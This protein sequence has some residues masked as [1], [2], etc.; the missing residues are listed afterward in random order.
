MLRCSFAIKVETLHI[1]ARS[2]DTLFDSFCM[3]IRIHSLK[4]VWIIS[5][6]FD[7]HSSCLDMTSGPGRELQARPRRGTESCQF[8]NR[9]QSLYSGRVFFENFISKADTKTVILSFQ[10]VS[11]MKEILFKPIHRRRLWFRCCGLSWT[12]NRPHMEIVEKMVFFDV[13]NCHNS[14]FWPSFLAQDVLRQEEQ[15]AT[16]RRELFRS[17]ADSKSS[18]RIIWIRKIRIPYVFSS[19]FSFSSVLYENLIHFDIH[20]LILFD[21]DADTPFWRWGGRETK[22]VG[23]DAGVGSRE[24]EAL[25]HWQ[26]TDVRCR[27]GPGGSPSKTAAESP[28]LSPLF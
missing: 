8:V 21:F 11:Q 18:C 6:F 25:A 1:F 13:T 17:Q 16:R 23:E 10:S 9:I 14:A 7:Y 2:F 4:F 3:F 26:T 12:A 24:A 22:R 27:A 5:I 28:S 20:G 15:A 19:V